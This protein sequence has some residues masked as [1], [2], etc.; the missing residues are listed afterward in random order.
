M[1]GFLLSLVNSREGNPQN[2]GSAVE[3]IFIYNQDKLHSARSQRVLVLAAILYDVI[4][5]KSLNFWK[6]HHR[7]KGA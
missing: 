6:P 1:T 2:T 7:M 5:N 4:L 3:I